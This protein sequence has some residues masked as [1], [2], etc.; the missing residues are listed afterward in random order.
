MAFRDGTDP[1]TDT[2][3]PLDGDGEELVGTVIDNRYR[4]EATIGRGGMGLV[5]RASH[6][7]L[8]RQVALK[9]LHPS[10]A[11]SSDVRNRFERE[12]LS[13]GRVDH[14]N[15]VT[16]YDVGRLPGGALYLAMELLEG[17]ALS[18]VL[19]REGQIPPA[20]ALHILAHILR[21]LGGIHRAGLIH[22]DIKPE[23]IFLIRQGDDVEFA[24]ILD[25]GIAKPLKGEID[26][27]VKLTQAG[28]AFGTPIYMAP[29]QA[30][31]APMDGRADLYAA[32]VVGYEMLAG[33][34]PFY[35]DD[36][37]EVMSMHTAK[38]VPP[39]RQRLGKNG[40]PV[41]S[42]IEKIVVRG[43]TKKPADRY[44][45]ADEFLAAVEHALDTR[46]GGNTDIEFLKPST[47]GSQSLVTESG[48]VRIVTGEES[49]AAALDGDTEGD[50]LPA[51]VEDGIN[52][53]IDEAIAIAAVV[54]APSANPRASSP[55]VS[56]K[57]A[58]PTKGLGGTE[59]G[60]LVAKKPAP[61]SA[62]DATILQA[63]PFAR[64]SPA[65]EPTPPAQQLAHAQA[66]RAAP[67][68]GIGI[69]LPY[70]GP[71]GEP[72]FG[73]TPEQ[74]LA[75]AARPPVAAP[76][77]TGLAAPPPIAG[78][79]RK[80]W[81]IYAGGTGIAIAAGIVVGVATHHPPAPDRDASP[82][83]TA[84]ADAMER[85]DVDGAIALLTQQGSAIAADPAAQRIL[86]HAHAARSHYVDA[87]TAYAHA[88][89]LA[90]EL[91]ADP[92]L[93]ADLRTMAANKDPAVVTPA[94]DMWL[95]HTSDA[96]A[97]RAIAN[98]AVADDAT[99]RHAV[100]AVI[101]K[102]KADD[103]VDWVQAYALDLQ[104]G[105]TCELRR[106]AVVKLRALNDARAVQA[107]ELASVRQ[108][109]T[110]SRTKKMNACLV[111][112][113]TEAIGYLRGLGK[114]P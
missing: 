51:G 3:V 24:K 75:R 14:P 35:S 52:A 65:A 63:S 64:P 16:T 60:R 46:D 77:E 4:L 98:A 111:D 6:L 62:G 33:Q 20:R 104:Q 70:T 74:R 50:D 61:V 49:L 107:L 55:A 12:A 48:K 19:E 92:E 96:A 47:T 73:L 7:G 58:T 53:A 59:L 103:A 43:L 18:E 28:M 113:A 22:R 66:A 85:G 26:D 45:S 13:V 44:P 83:D 11:A 89:T 54:P 112:A 27:G 114:H 106:D 95:G 68:G 99:R 79:R 30:L 109:A 39:I 17:R 21:G 42:S 69:G 2:P 5:Y 10:L 101:T 56:R 15:C 38:P 87:L 97:K 82:A 78:S 29:E 76:V 41:P 57:T 80:R 93:R 102:Y 36:K 91:E 81:P 108:G 88:L 25:F 100:A 23:N 86:G 110:G 90:P 67:A 32:A 84:A 34:P 72:I 71:T 40:R 9:I 105:A 37:L 8:R 94:F 1:A 31:G